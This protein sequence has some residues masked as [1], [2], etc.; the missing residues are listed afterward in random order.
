MYAFSW[1]VNNQCHSL[2]FFSKSKLHQWFSNLNKLH[3]LLLLLDNMFISGHYVSEW[4]NILSLHMFLPVV[5]VMR[6]V[7]TMK[8]SK[9]VPIWAFLRVKKFSEKIIFFYVQCASCLC[10]V[11][12]DP[13]CPNTRN[14]NCLV[15]NIKPCHYYKETIQKLRPGVRW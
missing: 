9:A 5:W 6:A 10:A 3:L 8:M 15:I 1:P 4:N 13:N 7:V 12:Q 2:G 11:C 14:L